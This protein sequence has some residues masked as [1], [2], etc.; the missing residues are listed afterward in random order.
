MHV[1]S[2]DDISGHQATDDALHTFA[3]GLERHLRQ[4]FSHDTQALS[5][6]KIAFQ[7]SFYQGGRE[8]KSIPR[9]DDE[10]YNP[11]CAR[12][13]QL[14]ISEALI[15]DESILMVAILMP[16]LSR[17]PASI[18]AE[19]LVSQPLVAQFIK[20]VPVQLHE[21]IQTLSPDPQPGLELVILADCIDHVRHLHLS[22]RTELEQQSL[23]KHAR[24][25]LESSTIP[26]QYERLR[27][28]L[29]HTLSQQERRCRA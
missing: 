5:R 20:S 24:K 16:L 26:A 13:A 19:P 17:L 11:R 1:L 8:D 21:T 10:S 18:A 4:L 25:V 12:L 6:L 23:L 9:R 15:A 2:T 14:L 22:S 28:M 29:K 3:P 27:T 7:F